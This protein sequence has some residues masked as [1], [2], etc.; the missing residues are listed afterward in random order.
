MAT[1]TE[2]LE[3]TKPSADDYYDIEVHNGNMD[4]IDD[5]VQHLTDETIITRQKTDKINEDMPG[6]KNH[7]TATN[8]HGITS[9]TV[10]LDKVPNVAT[11][12]Q[13]PTYTDTTTLS[14]LTSGERLGVAFGKI[15]KAITDLIS[16]LADTTKH[17]TSTE[18]SNWNGKAPTNHLSTT[19]MFG[20]G[21]ETNYG[22]LKITDSKSSTASDTAASAK[23]LK[24]VNDMAKKQDFELIKTQT[25]AFEN[26]STTESEA[27]NAK[28]AIT[29]IDI[30]SYKEL[31]FEFSGN[32]SLVDAS[33][34]TTT[35]FRT[36]ELKLQ[37]AANNGTKNP[38]KEL[39]A[40][41]YSTQ[42]GPKSASINF[43]NRIRVLIDLNEYA[44]TIDNS[45]GEFID[46]VLFMHVSGDAYTVR[47]INGDD[48]TFDICIN[49]QAPS[50]YA[51]NATT[52]ASGTVNIYGKKGY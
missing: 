4:I 10:G 30:T 1:K 38:E 34:T 12:D 44:Y 52:N 37:I 28:I 33:T 47:D 13:T 36:S 16:H 50:G 11:N 46:K 9:A 45:S 31:V 2:N 26:V 49:A 35:K 17:I 15:K 41:L 29:G 42:T 20:V 14:T 21:N 43:N 48:F 7:L 5:I 6:I 25:F 8:P 24:E 22:H 39:I 19:N 51:G 18:R 40:R 32:I 3:L 27:P 23:A